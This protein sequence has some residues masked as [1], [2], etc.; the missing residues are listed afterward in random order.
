MFVANLFLHHFENQRLAEL[1][2][3]I[4]RRAKLFIALEP[5]RSPW[6]L[7]CGRWLW[8]IGCNAVTRHDAIVSIRAGFADAELSALW[9]DRQNWRLA[10]CRAGSN[11]HL[12]VAQRIS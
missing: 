5:R 10:E 6:T 2:Q 12:F 11:G 9:P 1:L 7:F 4:S 3:K 8:A